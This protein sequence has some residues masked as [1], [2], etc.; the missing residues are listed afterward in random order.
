MWILVAIDVVF[1]I[2]ELGSGYYVGSLALVADAFHML[3]DVISLAVG[4]WAVRIAGRPAKGAYTYGWQRAEILGAFFNGVFLVALCVTIFLEAIQRLIDPPN[5]ENPELIGWVGLAGL[6]SNLF[7]LVLFFDHGHSHG[8]DGHDHDHDHADGHTHSH[9]EEHSH[10]H[11]AS[12]EAAAEEGRAGGV[13][14][15]GHVKRRT[16]NLSTSSGHSA[17]PARARRLSI[18]D[19]R[20]ESSIEDTLGHPSSMRQ[21]WTLGLNNTQRGEDILE[22]SESADE[23]AK[24]A[25]S[26]LAATDDAR[27]STANY[28]HDDHHHR[29]PKKAGGQSHGI[30]HNHGDLGMQGIFLHVLGDCLGNIGVILT[31][32]F[33]KFAHVSWKFYADPVISLIITCIILKSAIPLCSAASRILLQ[34]TPPGVDINEIENDINDMLDPTREPGTKPKALAHHLHVWQLTDTKLVA[35]VHVRVKGAEGAARYM[36]L[37]KAIHTCLHEYGIDSST[38]QPEFDHPDTSGASDVS[39]AVAP[40]Q[41]LMVCDDDCAR[42]GSGACCKPSAGASREASP[43]HSDHSGHRH[44]H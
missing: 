23:S 29:Q 34:A 12:A 11:R 42:D 33:I 25:I 6:G 10:S 41:C 38:I 31:A 32:I 8:D 28:S 20:R 7:G 35:S 36:S 39:T 24:T 44:E 1:L 15:S 18:K 43:G 37:A 14:D 3:N 26:N 16:K 27:G 21:E 5:I 40:E 19:G 4:L 2:I 9:G 30:G 22:E 13:T 17:S